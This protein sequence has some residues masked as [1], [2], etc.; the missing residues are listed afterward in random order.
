MIGENTFGDTMLDRLV[1]HTHLLALTGGWSRR[2]ETSESP[3]DYPH[4]PRPCL[5]DPHGLNLVVPL[6]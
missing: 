2:L 1:C 4:R 6:Q 5:N 3:N